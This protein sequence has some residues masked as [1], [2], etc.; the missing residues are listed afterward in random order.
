MDE[1]HKAAIGERI[2]SLRE[3]SP[4]KQQAV[5]DRLGIGL[6][7]YQKLEEVGTTRYERCE[8]LAEIFNVDPM[9]IWEGRDATA[10]DVLGALN[11]AP[12][13]QLT[14]IEKQLAAI[15]QQ[16]ADLLAREKAAA[17]RA[18]AQERR[19]DTQQP[20]SRRRKASGSSP[21]SD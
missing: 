8:E 18:E 5:A 10:P 12:Q 7:A 21:A 15:Q 9:W 14:R 19:R 1:A 17:A 6:R 3:R 11:G 20:P 16:L 13:S 2:R 4:F